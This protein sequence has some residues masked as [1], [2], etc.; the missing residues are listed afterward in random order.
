MAYARFGEGDVYLIGT[1]RLPTEEVFYCCGCI[2]VETYWRDEPDSMFGGYIVPVNEGE[3]YFTD[4]SRQKT[5]DHLREHL[6]A[7]H[8]VPDYAFTGIAEETEWGQP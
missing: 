8:E 3:T 7:G 2:L 4:P 6:A 1:Y 5:M